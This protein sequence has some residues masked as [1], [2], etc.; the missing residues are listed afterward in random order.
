VKILIIQTAFL[1][2][3]VLT[4]PLIQAAK[5]YLKSEVSVLCIPSTKDILVGHPD[6]DEIIVYDKKGKD[7]GIFNLFK[8][9]KKIREK[10]YDTVLIPHPSF[11]SGFL[12]YLSGIKKRVGFCNSAGRFFLTKCIPF[13]KDKCQLERYLD[14]MQYFGFELEKEKTKIYIDKKSDEYADSTL[15]PST[16][17][18]QVAQGRY[19]GINP[20]SVWATKRWLPERYAEL[21]DKIVDKFGGKIIIFGG[22][23][24][25]DTASIVEKNMKKHPINLAGKTTLKQLTALI[26]RCRVFITN[27]SGSMHIAAA[28][29]IPTVA[30]FGPTVKR[31]GFF[32]YSDKAVVIEKDIKC[33]PCD[34]HGSNKC[35]RNHFNCMNK[36]TVDEV[37]G[38]VKKLYEY[39]EYN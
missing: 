31:F 38:A 21:S 33:R 11:Q 15:D 13:D 30:I 3:V 25:I 8:L 12:A 27:D 19:F 35:P 2:D 4:I 6:I 18:G 9:A 16:S 37:F 23:D 24:D 5:K 39:F 26:K 7:R 22:V 29:D 10:K 17:S 1:G 36:V 28:L 14:L 32:P 20:G 34:R